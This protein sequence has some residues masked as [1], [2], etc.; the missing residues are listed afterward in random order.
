M[1]WDAWCDQAITFKGK[2][3]GVGAGIFCR[4][5]GAPWGVKPATF[6]IPQDVVM[7]IIQHIEGTRRDGVVING[8]KYMFLRSIE[9]DGNKYAMFKCKQ[10]GLTCAL[11]NKCVI[12]GK[13]VEGM[14]GGQHTEAV[15][16]MLTMLKSM[17][18]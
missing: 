17:N 11:A 12:I 7:S 3:V 4:Q 9:T 15:Y 8:N 14:Q 16:N 6:Q 2:T 13:Y 18:Y 10:D 5:S 1:S